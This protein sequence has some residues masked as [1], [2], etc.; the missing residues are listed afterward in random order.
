MS[1]VRTAN[2]TKAD[3]YRVTNPAGPFPPS[4]SYLDLML[5]GAREHQLDADYIE[6]LE[7][8]R[9]E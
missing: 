8:L 9:R 4:K 5:E 1:S 7:S 6:W 2:G 3:L